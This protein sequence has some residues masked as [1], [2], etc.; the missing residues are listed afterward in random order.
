MESVRNFL[1]SIGIDA[2][3]AALVVSTA[4]AFLIAGAAWFAICQIQKKLRK[5]PRAQLHRGSSLVLS[6]L[7]RLRP[8]LI[9]FVIFLSTLSRWS[10][11]GAEIPK[12]MQWVV[13]VLITFQ[14]G[15]VVDGVL[16]PAFREN[17]KIRESAISGIGLFLSRLA[18]WIILSLIILDN[19]GVKITALV[20]GL[21]VGGI[22]IALAV[23][24]IL[25]DV[26]SSLTIALDKPFA[27]G[28]VIKLGEFKGTVENV[29][30]KTTHVRSENG[31]LLVFP[32]SDLLQSRLSNFGRMRERRVVFTLG[33]TYETPHKKI[34]KACKIIEEVITSHE[35]ARFDRAHFLNFNASSLDL[36]VAYW[37]RSPDFHVHADL[38]Q[39]INLAIFERFNAEGIEFA[40]PTQRTIGERFT[41]HGIET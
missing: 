13:F 8:G 34:A 1:Q 10:L 29:G 16:K 19:F 3:W 28:D 18:L 38:R 21:G 22:A 17:E 6:G 39:S 15:F 30:I 40:Y 41:D 14:I 36:E 25:E 11:L 7:S 24:S 31:E 35:T 20:A 2:V 4:L 12:Y 27:R 5:V 9:F 23:K 33:I 26:F 32:N 37:V